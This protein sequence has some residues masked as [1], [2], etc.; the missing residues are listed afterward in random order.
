MIEIQGKLKRISCVNVI[1][2]KAYYHA[3]DKVG[4]DENFVHIILERDG[5]KLCGNWDEMCFDQ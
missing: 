1:F 4:K 3:K 2:V 5:F